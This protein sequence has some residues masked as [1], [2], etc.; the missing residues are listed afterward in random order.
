MQKFLKILR[1]FVAPVAL[2]LAGPVVAQASTAAPD[3]L[4]RDLTADVLDTAMYRAC[5][6]W[7]TKRS[8][9]TSTSRR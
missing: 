2:V 3:V 8:C 1:F 5:R 4:V 7:S 9:R 6:S